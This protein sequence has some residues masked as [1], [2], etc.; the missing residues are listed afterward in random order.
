MAL[1]KSTYWNLFYQ[2]SSVILSIISGILMAPLYLHYI[3]S[4]T[5]AYWLASGNILIWITII[6]PGVGITLEQKVAFTA[7]QNNK[8]ELSKLIT[9]G[10]ILCS[11]ILVASFSISLLIQQSIPVI[12]DLKKW[13]HTSL[14][15]EAFFWASIG[16]SLSLCTYSLVGVNQGLQHTAY[17]GL[18]YLVSQ[19]VG[20]VIS[21]YGLIQ[22]W[23]LLSIGYSRAVTGV[24]YFVGNGLIFLYALQKD[25]IRLEY[26]KHYFKSFYK[27]FSY[28]FA[29][30]MGITIAN[31]IDLIVVSRFL[32]PSIITQLELSRRPQ[33]IFS[34]FVNRTTYALLPS[35]SHSFGKGDSNSVKTIYIQFLKGFIFISLIISFGFIIFNEA[36]LNFWVGAENYIGDLENVLIVL[37]IIIS[38]YTYS[39]SNFSFSAGNIKGNSKVGIYRSILYLVLIFPLTMYFG[40]VGLLAALI[41]S[42]LATEFWYYQLDLARVIGLKPSEVWQV[43]KPNLTPLLLMSCMAFYL[44]NLRYESLLQVVFVAFLFT[45]F[46]VACFYLTVP[47]IRLQV[48]IAIQ[49]F[50]RKAIPD[51][52]LNQ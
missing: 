29:N 47:E 18:V 27:I 19:L 37:S 35:M 21:I 48:S 31:N 12:L 44:H 42:Y 4:S 3:E 16:S 10:L 17:T 20:I 38:S 25:T 40:V 11:I 14:L 32:E 45:V 23:G 46:A 9:S 8:T 22:G 24:L 2:Y 43:V 28:T 51:Q 52:T 30:K 36:L 34:G 49:K 7:G 39:N 41:I 50:K 15:Q 26:D 1:N 5:Y 13:P 33:N 6:E